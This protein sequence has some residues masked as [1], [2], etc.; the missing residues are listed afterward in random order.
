VSAHGTSVEALA[1]AGYATRGVLYL[2]VG[3]LAA[4]AAFGHGGETT[5]TK[6]ALLEL[7]AQPFGAIL[8]SLAAAG[9]AGYAAFLVCRA[10]LDPEGEARGTWGPA[11]RAWWAL[12]ALL[13]AGLA[14]YA[15]S[16]V[17]GTVL[18]SHGDRD[19]ARGLTAALLAWRPFG[20]WLVAAVAGGILIGSAY[21]LR[22]AWTAKLDDYLDF[23]RLSAAGTRWLVRLSRVGIAARACV[24]LAAGGFLLVAAVTS[25]PNQAKGFA[26]SLSSLRAMPFGTWLFAFVALGLVAFGCYQLIEARYRRILGR[27]H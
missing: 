3:G 9:L 1:R 2:I 14:A 5:D 10:V 11:K 15:L 6:G 13:H 21:Q 25:N 27:A 26:D 24:G 7:Y 18:L 22:C 16:T 23:S 19:E 12:I 17:L 4:L 20:P 8:L